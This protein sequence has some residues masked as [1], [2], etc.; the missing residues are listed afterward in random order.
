MLT[1]P[2]I[3]AL[4]TA[5]PRSYIEVLGYKHIS[6]LALNPLHADAARSIES[7]TLAPFFARNGELPPDVAKHLASFELIISYLSDPDG[8]FVANVKRSGA[9]FVVCGP[10]KLGDSEHAAVQL[11]KPLRELNIPIN[12]F[13]AE[14]P[15]TR[16]GE[17]RIV[18]HPGS[19]SARKNWP[20]DRWIQLVQHLTGRRLLI[21]AGEADRDELA[22]I[23]A[24]LP[25]D[26]LAIAENLPLREVAEVIGSSDLFVGHDSGVSHIAAATGTR[27][28]L[29]FGPTDP[30]I[31][32]PVNQNVRVLRAPAGDLRR[33]EVS[34]VAQELMRIGINT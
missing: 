5:F 6:E 3:R 8:L 32:A 7:A 13:A 22:T 21:V 2:T 27:C 23:R 14:I 4:R 16:R 25:A 17:N 24:A 19:G 10:A 28:V 20:T 33:L 1:L 30:R 31:W 9:G 29:L 15:V 26:R 18:L 34:D 11:A 12:N